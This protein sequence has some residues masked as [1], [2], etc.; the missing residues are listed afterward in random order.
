MK[1]LI[2][3]SLLFS[4]S[5]ALSAQSEEEFETL[6]SRGYGIYIP[7]RYDGSEDL[8]LVIALHGFGDEW[9]NFSRFSGWMTIAEEYNFLVAF[10]N[11][12]LRQWNDGG[13]GDHYEDD[14]RMLQVM[15]ERVA[16][17]YRINR[18]RIYLTGFSNGGTMV[19]KAAC[20]APNVFA[21]IA[22]V[23]GTMRY[24]QNCLDD[25]QLSV[26]M[27]H[28]TADSVVPFTGGDGRYSAPNSAAFWVRQNACE[29]EA[30][31]DYDESLFVNNVAAYRYENCAAGHQVLLYVIEDMPHT[32]PGA[33]EYANGETPL[34]RIDA[35]RLIWNFFEAS[36]RT[37]QASAEATPEVP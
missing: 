23:A 16:R 3:L 17:D 2:L 36:Y 34:A 24:N 8:P 12:Y 28:G 15:I 18:E 32:W 7:S 26:M 14:V 37:E 10:P 27:I 20:E 5:M 35:P 31:P 30:V 4:L 29:T 21:G 22:S 9:H 25:L 6:E 19:Y 13:R 1:L 11:G 33:R